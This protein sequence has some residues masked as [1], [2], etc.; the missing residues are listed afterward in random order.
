MKKRIV[1][2]ALAPIKYFDISK[3]DNL[4]KV[5]RYINLAG[6]KKADIICFPESVLHKTDVLEINHPVVNEIQEECKKNNIWCIVTEDFKIKGKPF[7]IA[8]LINRKGKI[9]GHYKKIYIHDEKVYPGNKVKVFKTDFGKIG[10]VICWDL[11]FP[12]LFKKMNQKGAEIIFCPAEW[13]YEEDCPTTNQFY[14][15]RDIELLKS[16]VMARAFENMYFVALCNPLTSEEDQVSY[17][18]I[19]SPHRVLKETID[20]E[21]LMIADI[22]LNEI[23]ELKKLYTK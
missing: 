16:L 12:E 15:K 3:K 14:K 22:D 23:N 7:N 6:K 19:V 18:A 2:I 17:S 8:I 13:R 21:T 9:I 11:V 4:D 20:E 1:R 10:I 5:K